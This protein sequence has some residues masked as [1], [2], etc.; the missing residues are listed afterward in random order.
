MP[1]TSAFAARPRPRSRHFSIRR[2][3]ASGFDAETEQ[4]L[5]AALSLLNRLCDDVPEAACREACDPCSF[6]VTGARARSSCA[7]ADE[8]RATRVCS[9]TPQD[10]VAPVEINPQHYTRIF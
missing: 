7:G 9:C 8:K 3:F 2:L 1:T 6:R 4:E 10:L 5:Q